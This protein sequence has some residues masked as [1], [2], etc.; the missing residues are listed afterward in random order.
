[1]TDTAFLLPGFLVGL[2]VNLK[3]K[4]SSSVCQMTLEYNYTGTF[5]VSVLPGLISVVQLQFPWGGGGGR[6][7]GGHPLTL[8]ALSL[9]AQSPYQQSSITCLQPLEGSDAVRDFTPHLGKI[10][11]YL[12]Y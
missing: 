8:T 10:K 11:F 2:I 1:M 4:V 7:E 6:G 9:S 3:Y 5:Q 12:N